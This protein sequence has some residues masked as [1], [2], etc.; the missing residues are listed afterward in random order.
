MENLKE[1]NICIIKPENFVYSAIFI[2]QANYFS[3][4]FSKFGYKVNIK[5]NTLIE[6]VTNF[7]FGAW[8]GFDPKLKNKYPCIF[9]NLEQLGPNGSNELSHDYLD[10]LKNSPVIDYDEKNV[11]YYAIPNTVPIAPILYAPYLTDFQ[12]NPLKDRPIDI[13][14]FGLLNE[15]RLKIINKLHESGI[16]IEYIKTPTFGQELFNLI[17]ASKCVLNIHAYDSSIFEQARA[18]LCLSIGTPVVSERS[19][20]TNPHLA[21]DENIF[22]IEDHKFEEFFLTIFKSDEFYKASYKN[23]EQFRCFSDTSEYLKIT[24]LGESFNLIHNEIKTNKLENKGH[25]KSVIH[26][27][28]LI[29]NPSLSICIPILNGASLLEKTLESI[30]NQ[31]VF[32]NTDS[33]EIIISDN[34]SNDSTED[35]SRRFINLYPNKIFYYKNNENLGDRNFGISLSYGRGR[36]LKLHNHSFTFVK[37]SLKALLNIVEN[38]INEDTV[39]FF[40]NNEVPHTEPITITNSLDDFVNHAS[41]QSTWIGGFTIWKSDFKSADDFS[42]N[43]N[44]NLTQTENLFKLISIKNKAL[45]INEQIFESQIFKKEIS[46]DVSKVFGNSYI[47]ILKS[48]VNKGK[49]SSKTFLQEK[50]KI[51]KKLIL[52]YNFKNEIDFSNPLLLEKLINFQDEDFFS[53]AI[54]S[55]KND[56]KNK[57]ITGDEFLKTWNSINAHNDVNPINV[58]P[59]SK[60]KVGRMSYGPIIVRWWGHADE[61]LEIGSFCSIASD[62]EFLLGGNHQHDLISTYPFKVRYFGEKI[63][64]TTKGPII[65]KDDVWIG[66]RAMILSGVTI[67]QGAVIAAGTIVSKDVPPYA[68][69]AGNPGKIVRFRFPKS[70]IEILQQI[71]YNKMTDSFI[72]KIQQILIQPITIENQNYVNDILSE[73]LH[74]D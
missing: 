14:F 38:K 74:T 15:R 51:L 52:P 48:Y 5:F 46:Y 36:L 8:L 30:V 16:N 39:L 56:L 9:V 66:Q 19:S 47:N 49:I 64:A 65:I 67:G 7:V 20:H 17:K 29:K 59:I 62:V 57:L 63:E 58:F 72:K 43:F 27:E 2:D 37:D 18:S 22:W 53:E 42:S 61:K 21:Y 23:I 6:G 54:S 4:Q 44:N 26:E 13:L 60:V 32:L 28:G 3:Y 24:M 40:T 34:C 1:F 33:I 73:V 70:I 35:V 41:I 55:F 25:L 10:L 68:I 50:E 11:P 69:I 71:D 31:E 45:I 12:N